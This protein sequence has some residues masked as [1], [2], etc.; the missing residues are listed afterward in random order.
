MRIVLAVCLLALAVYSEAR[1]ACAYK[2]DGVWKVKEGVISS[3]AVAFAM[4]TDT[5]TE[6]GWSTLE[7][8]TEAAHS[9]ADQAYGAGLVEGY[10][11]ATRIGQTYINTKTDMMGDF[12]GEWDPL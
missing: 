12:G 1:I 6:D 10:L 4:Y 5:T 9:N 3:E 7:L 2:Q 8:H 11:T